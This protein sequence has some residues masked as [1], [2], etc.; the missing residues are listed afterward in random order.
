VPRKVISVIICSRD[1]AESLKETLRAVGETAV[2]ADMAVEVLVVDNGS[3]DRT[4]TV[5]R[6]TNLWGRAPRYIYEP[7]P[8]GSY[9]RNTG[10]AAA[11][12]SSQFNYRDGK[13]PFIER[14]ERCADHGCAGNHQHGHGSCD[15]A[16]D[17]GHTACW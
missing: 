1:R 17:A 5:V 15:L 4:R 11:Q 10:M 12:L 7:R 16:Q 6:Q 14:L 13:T 9:A 8:G 2:P 3:R